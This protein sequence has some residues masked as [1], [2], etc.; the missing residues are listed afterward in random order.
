M[1]VSTAPPFRLTLIP[2][3]LNFW[4][5]MTALLSSAARMV[6]FWPMMPMPSRLRT[7]LPVIDTSR[8]AAM[9]TRPSVLPIRLP[10]CVVSSISAVVS[11]RCLPMVKPKP[12]PENRPDFLTV[13]S[14]TSACVFSA[15]S[16]TTSRPAAN[17]TSPVP[18]ICAPCDVRS[19]PAATVTVSP[20]SVVV[21]AMLSC[22]SSCVVVVLLLR[23]PFLVRCSSMVRL[24]CSCAAV[25]LTSRPADNP[26]PPSSLV[27][28]A[29]CSVISRPACIAMLPPA[30]SWV[31]CTVSSEADTVLDQRLPAWL[32]SRVAVSVAATL[33]MSRP[34]CTAMALPAFTFA[35]ARLTSLP[36][37]NTT[38]PAPLTVL[39][40]CV[41][42]LVL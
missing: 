39:P 24:C 30:V 38:L 5:S 21:T 16:R 1:A 41:V 26:M 11:V 31:P 20:L 27:T 2:A 18:A 22:H 29:A 40:T 8:P 6:T 36:A 4:V 28:V 17:S 25:R 15:V 34:A 3:C 35:A 37:C 33:L 14:C 9:S 7:S 12:P 10:E 32:W 19:R 42:W 13:L 23:K